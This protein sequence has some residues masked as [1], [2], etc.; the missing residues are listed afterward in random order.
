MVAAR[1]VEGPSGQPRAGS[2]ANSGP[3]RDRSEYAP[4]LWSGKEICRLCSDRGPTRTP[5]QSEKARME[6]EQEMLV[7]L[8][9][10]QR[11]RDTKY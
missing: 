2:G 7:R 10:E 5:R 1:K 4:K 9:N 6:P 3:D 8:S 11:A